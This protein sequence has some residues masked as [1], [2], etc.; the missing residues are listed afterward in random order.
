MG[1][2]RL[3]SQLAL[4]LLNGILYKAVASW[5]L[6]KSKEFRVIQAGRLT[7][8]KFKPRTSILQQISA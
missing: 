6:I 1:E 2:L 8:N 7:N 3:P 5:S 4:K